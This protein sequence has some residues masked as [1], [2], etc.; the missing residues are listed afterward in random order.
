[1]ELSLFEEYTG[2][3]KLAGTKAISP[4]YVQIYLN[5][6]YKQLEVKKDSMPAH[7]FW[8][9]KHTKDTINY[10]YSDYYRHRTKL[11]ITIN[12]TIFDTTRVELNYIARDSL[13]HNKK[14]ALTIVNQSNIPKSAGDNK[15]IIN[16][17]ELFKPLKLNFARPILEINELKPFRLVDDSAKKE[18]PAKF[19]IEE[20]TKMALVINF[21]KEENTS[22]TLDVPD[23][24]FSDIFGMWNKK[25]IYKFKTNLKDNYGNLNITLKST[26][27]EKHYIVKLLNES[28]EV[29][30]EIPFSG[31]SIKKVSVQN[32]PSGNYKFMAIDDKNNNGIWDSGSFKNKIQPEKV[33]NFKDSYF[34]KGGWDLDAEV[35]IP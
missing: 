26:H 12:D 28:G 23:S 24:A 34:L 15:D 35:I 30:K 2:K 8:Y 21:P 25:F 22:Y 10:W 20:K 19:E 14:Y 31:D 1:M 6:P 7:D 13:F 17:Q 18:I 16:T 3:M 27:P 5:K 33:I 11:F 29:M 4:G 32:L 9:P